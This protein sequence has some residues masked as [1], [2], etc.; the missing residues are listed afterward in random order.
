[1]PRPGLR[2]QVSRLP[3]HCSIAPAL[4]R[5]PD[6]YDLLT[7]L[8]GLA[9]EVVSFAGAA[10]VEAAKRAIDAARMES[11]PTRQLPCSEVETSVQPPPQAQ[12]Q[13]QSEPRSASAAGK[14]QGADALE[15][16]SSARREIA[17]AEAAQGR[18][19]RH[20]ANR[21]ASWF[22]ARQESLRMKAGSEDAKIYGGVKYERKANGPFMG[23]LVS[24]GNIITI[25]G[26]DYVEYRVLTKSSFF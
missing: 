22:W 1:M 14:A 15:R 21:E 26:E 3:L 4:P 2:E 17:R 18:A 12:P 20:A 9:L 25:D 6:D 24:Q 16:T 23:K 13:S 19:D 8:D 10:G 5:M 7:R 11:R